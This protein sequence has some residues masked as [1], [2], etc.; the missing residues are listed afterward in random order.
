MPSALTTIEVKEVVRDTPRP[1]FVELHHKVVFIIRSA[2]VSFQR[3]KSS[4]SHARSWLGA[5]LT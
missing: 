2:V 5:L 4:Q 3:I 1:E